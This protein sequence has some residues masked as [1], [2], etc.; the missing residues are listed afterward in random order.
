[1][2]TSTINYMPLGSVI[3]L[4]GGIQKL[5]IIARALNV[6]NEG[7]QYFFDYGGVPYP[8]GL[9]G[10]QIAYFNQEQIARVIFEGYHDEDDTIIVNNIRDYIANNPGVQRFKTG[11]KDN[12]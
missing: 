9:T 3:Q 12:S 11:K 2:E 10:D 8:E 5:L 6:N 1:M 7:K 4:K